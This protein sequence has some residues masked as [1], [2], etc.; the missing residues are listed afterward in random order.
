MPWF[1]RAAPAIVYGSV[2]RPADSPT[3]PTITPLTV[4]ALVLIAGLL[5]AFRTAARHVHNTLREEMTTDHP[6][7]EIPHQRNRAA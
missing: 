1:P 4:A 7:P 3:E 2:Q 6:T 5:L